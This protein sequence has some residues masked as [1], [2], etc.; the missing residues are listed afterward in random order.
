V[1]IQEKRYGRRSGWLPYVE[2]AFG[3]YFLGMVLFAIDTY[4]FLSIPFLMLF[5]VGYYYAGITTLYQEQ[6]GRLRFLRDQRRVAKAA[7]AA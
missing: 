1:R 5:V 2:L 4:N 6:H 7:G 3:T